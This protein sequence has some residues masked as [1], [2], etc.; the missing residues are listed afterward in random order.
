[1]VRPRWDAEKG[2]TLFEILVTVAVGALLVFAV[3]Y[4]ANAFN[5][6]LRQSATL[7]AATTGAESLIDS[8]E[9]DAHSGQA[10]FTPLRDVAG[11]DN[12]DG[13]EIGFYARDTVGV[14]HFWSYCYKTGTGKCASAQAANAIALYRYAWSELPQNGGTGPTLNGSVAENITAFKSQTYP[15]SSLLDSTINPISAAYFRNIG[16]TQVVDVPRQM[17]FS[18]VVGGNRVTIVKLQTVAGPRVIHLV[19]SEMTTHR[20]VIVGTYTPPP[21]ALNLPNGSSLH[22]WSPLAPQQTATFAESNYGTRT[23]NPPQVYTI[24][25]TSCP[26][27]TTWNPNPTI[28][29]AHDGTGDGQLNVTPIKRAESMGE[30]CGY[31]VADNVGQTANIGAVVDPT[32]LPAASY[33]TPANPIAGQT[34]TFNVREGNYAQAPL[35]GFSASLSGGCDSQTF[36]SA[37]GGG[38]F[39]APAESE[40]W[41]VHVNGTGVCTITFTDTYGQQAQASITIAAN[42]TPAPSCRLTAITGGAVSNVAVFT[43]PNPDRYWFNNQVFE[44]TAGAS[45]GVWIQAFQVDALG[46]IATPTNGYTIWG[47]LDGILTGQCNAAITTPPPLA[48]PPPTSTP[49]PPTSVCPPTPSNQYYSQGIGGPCDNVVCT[50]NGSPYAPQSGYADYTQGNWWGPCGGSTVTPTATPF[51]GGGS[52]TPAPTC[53][54]TGGP[55]PCST[56]TPPGTRTVTINWSVDIYTKSNCP[57][58]GS[59]CDTT[60]YFAVPGTYTPGSGTTGPDPKGRIAAAF[61]VDIV[62]SKGVPVPGS[63]TWDGTFFDVY[64]Y[65]QS[66]TGNYPAC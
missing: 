38:G 6:S 66:C 21:N 31:T 48:T 12:S 29:P 41:S 40:N 14:G 2:V 24:V 58:I 7:Q 34:V 35:G 54:S 5:H 26:P 27:Y 56:S 11:N 28:I 33:I 39:G 18:G 43:G 36:Q 49:T 64:T 10:I 45:G 65:T 1:M 59:G 4:A 13:H 52:P 8:L 23:T 17:G 3:L 42:A 32:Q 61:I 50:L 57:S 15:A 9:R 19:A 22:F 62:D 51:Q 37:G 20:L 44:A 60:Y 63:F 53:A 55:L 47:V 16:I 25:G 30:T 46:N